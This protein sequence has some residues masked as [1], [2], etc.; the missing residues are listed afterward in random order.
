M[1]LGNVAQ[2]LGESK[3]ESMVSAFYRRVRED[4]LIGPMYPKDD[5]EGAEKRLADFLVFRFGGSDRYIK[6]RGHP[7]LRMRHVNFAI[8]PAESER[9]LELMNEAMKETE[10]SAET[11]SVL[12]PFFR[13]VAE[14][15]QNR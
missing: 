8:G 1:D 13:Q 2:T 10:I 5:W 4:D 14:F 12:T 7:R 11:V 3:I 15:M 6:E 9:W